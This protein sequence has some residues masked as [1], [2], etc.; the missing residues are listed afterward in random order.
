MESD[1]ISI[2]YIILSIDCIYPVMAAN[3]DLNCIIIEL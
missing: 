1:K 3:I 2:N